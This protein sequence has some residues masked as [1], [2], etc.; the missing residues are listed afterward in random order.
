MLQF[1]SANCQ[2]AWHNLLWELNKAKRDKPIPQC[3]RQVALREITVARWHW[4]TWQSNQ[5][6]K[7]LKTFKSNQNKN[8]YIM[9]SRRQNRAAQNVQHFNIFF[10]Q[11]IVINSQQQRIELTNKIYPTKKLNFMHYNKYIW[12]ENKITITRYIKESQVN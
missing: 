3:S 4:Y 7:K 6:N 8:L 2:G 11:I 1:P 5:Y 9:I 10:Y 12:L